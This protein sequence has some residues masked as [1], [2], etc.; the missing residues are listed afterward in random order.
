MEKMDNFYNLLDIP[1]SASKKQIIMG[2]EN[3]I[4]K[5][6]AFKKL[7]SEQIKEIKQLKTSLYILTNDNLRKKYDI[8]IKKIP[9]PENILVS[10]DPVAGNLENEDTFDSVFSVDN[11]WMKNDT[12][13]NNKKERVSSNLLGERV[14]SLPNY[15]KKQNYSSDV[16]TELR[17]PLQCR[18]D[19]TKTNE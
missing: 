5:Y 8:L 12:Q 1:Y 10:N 18:D 16:D 15:N 6:N 9:S 2:Y 19:K 3:K 11:S 14:F 4:S 17:K 7:S 13:S